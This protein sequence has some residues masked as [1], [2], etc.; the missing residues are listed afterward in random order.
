MGMN[1]IDFFFQ[2]LAAAL[3]FFSIAWLIVRNIGGQRLKI[4]YPFFVLG[5]LATA[6]ISSLIRF[7]SIF[8]L[9]GNVV[10]HPTGGY[11]AFFFIAVPASTAIIICLLLKLEAKSS[12]RPNEL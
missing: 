5:V 2:Y 7:S 11:N 10:L 1:F 3:I 6:S 9:G 8:V 4:G 12:S